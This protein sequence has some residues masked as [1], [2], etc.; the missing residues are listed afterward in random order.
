MESKLRSRTPWSEKVNR[1]A[2]PKI[3]HI[4]P[5]W[6]QWQRQFGGGTMLIATP[7]HIQKLMEKARKGRLLTIGQIRER[8]AKDFGTTTTCPLTTGI[9]ARI[10]AEAANEELESGKLRVT[11]FW[12]LIR[13]DGTLMEKFPG[14]AAEQAKLLRREGHTIVAS[15]TKKPPRVKDHERKLVTL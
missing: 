13:D 2:E 9:F 12:R 10:V 8:L 4:K 14:G 15:K 7:R 5:G 6:G 11:P 1:P 3:V